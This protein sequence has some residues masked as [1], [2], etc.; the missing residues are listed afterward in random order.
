[1][2]ENLVEAFLISDFVENIDNCKL[3]AVRFILR[4]DSVK[5]T[6]GSFACAIGDDNDFL[7]FAH[8]WLLSALVVNLGN[9]FILA[10][11]FITQ[12]FLILLM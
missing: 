5:E 9:L 1:M 8:F 7:Q 4:Q 12:L 10:R 2:T 3:I 11:T 6:F